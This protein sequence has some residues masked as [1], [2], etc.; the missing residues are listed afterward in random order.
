MWHT[1]I[2]FDIPIVEATQMQQ[3]TGFQSETH[4]S[5][6]RRTEIDAGGTVGVV[7]EPVGGSDHF[8]VMLGG[9]YGGIPEGP[10]RRL[11][12]NGVC[13][14]AL[15]YFGAPGLPPALVEIPIEALQQGIELFSQRFA[16]GRAVG[17]MGFSKG[18]ELALVLGAH[19][20][21]R[22]SR[23]VAVAPSHVVWFGLKP[24]GPDPDRRST[25]SSWSLGGVPLPF[26]PCPPVVMPA[27]SERGLRTDVFFDLSRHQPG[28]VD[29]AR[30]AVER[31][32][33]PILLLSGD[34]DHQWP[35]V[36]MANELVRRMQNHG[37]GDDVTSVTYPGA[38]HIFLVQDF[39]PAPKPGTVPLYDFGGSTEAD[40]AA[41]K[42]AWP[43]I[44]SFLHA[45]GGP[46][47]PS[48]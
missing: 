41:G 36:P 4:S 10:A 20:G 18:A 42:D 33:S 9:S 3:L 17:L 43:R 47:T 6:V 26:L 39:M 1:A 31:S 19:L 11:A 8:A 12:E 38:G 28:D 37:R 15:G 32:A 46:A 24:P 13:A 16:G 23:I 29:A 2:V 14:F 48:R 45:S 30:I 34:D 40:R 7:F 27:F 22:I 5:P 25:K 35:A 21:G 44:V